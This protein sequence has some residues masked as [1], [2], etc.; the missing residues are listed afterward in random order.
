MPGAAHHSLL[1]MPG[2]RT[3]L[4]HFDVVIGF[5]HHGIAIAQVMLYQFRHVAEIGDDGNFDA[6]RTEGKP[7]W[8]GGI[9]WNRKRCYLDVA[10]SERVTRLNEID[11]R[12]P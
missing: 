1:D 12:Q 11:T 10:N 7:E 3:H 6:T 5:E 9:V 4:E 2:V 8:V